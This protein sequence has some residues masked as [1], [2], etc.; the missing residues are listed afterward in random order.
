MHKQGP[1][2]S[3]W[4]YSTYCRQH[5]L[6]RY[7]CGHERPS[8]VRGKKSWGIMYRAAEAE[9]ERGEGAIC[10]VWTFAYIPFVR[11]LAASYMHIGMAAEGGEKVTGDTLLVACNYTAC[12][13]K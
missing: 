2:S 7:K 11:S 13:H 4:V 10:I 8:C 1:F 5:I 12:K 9:A 6:G 3:K